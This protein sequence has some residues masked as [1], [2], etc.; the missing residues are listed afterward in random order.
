MTTTSSFSLLRKAVFI[1]ILVALAIQTTRA[2]DLGKVKCPDEMES[3]QCNDLITL[4]EEVATVKDVDMRLKEH[5]REIELL[6]EIRKQYYK[7]EYK[8]EEKDT[9]DSE[10]VVPKRHTFP[11][12]DVEAEK[13]LSGYQSDSSADSSSIRARLSQK[14]TKDLIKELE[15]YEKLA[16]DGRTNEKSILGFERM[17]RYITEELCGRDPEMRRGTYLNPGEKIC[18]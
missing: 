15:M 5:Y 11:D 7:L 8:P 12:R 14:T 13:P 1:A 9:N 17:I 10:C 6:R 18:E 16:D 4:S 3:G 2:V